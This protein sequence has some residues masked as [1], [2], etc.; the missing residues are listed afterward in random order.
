MY[1]IG[2]LAKKAGVS[3][4]AIRFYEKEGLLDGSARTKSGYRLFPP[5]VLDRVLYIKRVQ[6]AGATLKDV[7][8]A[9]EWRK[10]GREDCRDWQ[11]VL[12][13]RRDEYSGKLEE[14][15]KKLEEVEKLLAKTGR[16]LKLHM[17]DPD[18]AASINCPVLLEY[19]RRK[20]KCLKGVICQN[21]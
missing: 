5:G 8:Q 14:I 4:Q 3:I 10:G 1:K 2:D 19:S 12:K 6:K 9:L 13:K 18:K 7:R 21:N 20:V 17:A 11:A 16:C 15:E